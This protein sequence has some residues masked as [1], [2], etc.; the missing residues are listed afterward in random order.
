MPSEVH[1]HV[2]TTEGWSGTGDWVETTTTSWKQDGEGN[3]QETADHKVEW[4]PYEA[5]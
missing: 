3:W 4:K 1:T 2:V 5:S